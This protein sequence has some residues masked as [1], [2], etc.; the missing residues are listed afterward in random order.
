MQLK[1]AGF[2]KNLQNSLSIFTPM[3]RAG[4]LCLA[5]VCNL[6]LSAQDLKRRAR[7]GIAVKTFSGTT[8]VKA[9]AEITAV[10]KGGTGDEMNLQ[11]GQVITAVNK[12][13]INSSTELIS[14]LK[15]KCEGDTIIVMVQDGTSTRTVMGQLQAAA[16]DTCSGVNISY[17]SFQMKNIR[18]RT[19]MWKPA[20][21]APRAT[22]YYLQGIS[23]YALDNLSNQDPTRLAFKNLV[24]NGFAVYMVEKPGMGDSQSNCPCTDLRYLQELEV[25]QA[26]YRHL[27]YDLKTDSTKVFLFGHSMGG[28]TAPLL[29]NSIQPKGTIVFGTV[30]KPWADYLLDAYI[31]QQYLLGAPLSQLRDTLELCKPS[32]YKLFYTTTSIAS[33]KK[34]RHA[35]TMLRCILE[36]DS[37][38]NLL[39]AGRSLQ[40]HK[41]LNALN[42][43]AAWKNNHSPLLACYGESDIAANNANDHVALVNYVNK[44]RPGKAEFRLVKNT[45]HTFQAIGSM[46][47]FVRMQADVATYNQFAANNFNSEFFLFLSEWMNQQL[48]RKG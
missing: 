41:E 7:M 30:F 45:N 38:T 43:A 35:K 20:D 21:R 28:I 36:Y 34:E 29:A 40:F 39:A 32:F 33:I 48:E 9:G 11:V 17:G 3:I 24:K 37:V 46:A 12:Q 5:L 4:L 6:L 31:E 14:L 25:Y 42:L 16:N 8:F 26:G 2:D 18:L 44:L 27:V 22:V 19:I 15:T 23:C 10:F 1:K 13:K 47:D